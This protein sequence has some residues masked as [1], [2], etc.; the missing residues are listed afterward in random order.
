MLSGT[1]HVTTLQRV[2][3][4]AA[5]GAERAGAGQQPQQRELVEMVLAEL[6]AGDHFGELALL[7]PAGL[8]A[9]TV[10]AVGPA[11][12]CR[13]DAATFLQVARPARPPAATPYGGLLL[14]L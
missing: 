8:R 7:D 3:E 13:L 4:A 9:A 14:Q 2:G 11:E 12:L 1:L 10:R 5:G 6:G